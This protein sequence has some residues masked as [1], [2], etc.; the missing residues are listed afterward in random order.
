MNVANGAAKGRE[1]KPARLHLDDDR[2]WLPAR[3]EQDATYDILLND[4]HVWS[5]QPARDAAG[6]SGNQRVEWPSA[7]RRYLRG[8]ADVAFREHVAGTVLAR[9]SHVFG[10]AADRTVRV[11]DQHGNALILDKWGRLIR[12]LASDADELVDELV[13]RLL[14]MM[15][16]ILQRT[17]LPVFLC[18]GTLLGAV[19]DGR[20]IGHDN[21]VD[22][23]YASAESHPVD[24]VREG[25]RV[26]RALSAAGWKVRRG[27]GVRLNISI[28]LSDGS[29]RFV[30]V[31]SANWVEGVLYIPSDLGVR[32]P[33]E[34]VLPLG[35]VTLHGR[36]VPAPHDPESVLAA[37][38]GERW[39]VPDPSFRYDSPRSLH[40]RFNG[41]YG[42]LITGRKHWG[43]FA[44]AAAGSVP[45][46]PTPFARWVAE[47]YPSARPLVDLGAGTGRD[48]LWFAGQGRQVT[49]V[50]YVPR[51]VLK[52][53]R[54]RAARRRRT[55]PKVSVE[56]LN[57]SDLRAVLAFGARLSRS[58]EP[59]DLYA[60]FL[61][62]GMHR[63]GRDHVFR[64]ASMSLRRGGFLFLEFRTRQ[65]RRRRKTFSGPRNYLA[66]RRV[67]SQIERA[68]GEVVFQTQGTGLAPFRDEDPHVCRMVVRW[69]RDTGGATS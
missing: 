25:F 47:Q 35:T 37:T 32:L 11:T 9:T 42:G 57:L 14:E 39:R 66:P 10:D 22:I 49:A 56:V 65:D 12:P 23:A 8:H 60:R 34:T 18:Y 58:D 55:G 69:S 5:L 28:A 4:Q 48:T 38:Y 2:V 17:G 1:T 13:E 54:E 29:V 41:W 20:F 30:D 6:P 16:T 43:R 46:E 21:D 15:G 36:E 33:R 61:L 53:L 63:Q 7:L 40:R 67:R 24:I 44:A 3:V 52:A 19:R 51:S 64:L 45:D 62:H 31:F 26:E 50:D 27:S 68:G 59:V